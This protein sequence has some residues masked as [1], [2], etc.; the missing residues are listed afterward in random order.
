M[1]QLNDGTVAE[2]VKIEI[3]GQI[4]QKDMDDGTVLIFR[5][6]DQRYPKHV[7][8]M[9]VENIKTNVIDT[10]QGQVKAMILPQ[11]IEVTTIRDILNDVVNKGE[12]N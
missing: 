6:D 5:I 12:E 7:L 2:E 9:L 10:F 3:I 11:S 1:S 8:D 4:S